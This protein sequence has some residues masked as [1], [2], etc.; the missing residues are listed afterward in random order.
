MQPEEEEEEDVCPP[1]CKVFTFFSIG[2]Y[3]QM[4]EKSFIYVA[5]NSEKKPTKTLLR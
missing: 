4:F 1:S 3:F 5:L 2:L